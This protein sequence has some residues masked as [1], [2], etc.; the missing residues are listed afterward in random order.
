M[1]CLTLMLFMFIHFMALIIFFPA[2]L[3]TVPLHILYDGQQARLRQEK[4]FE[5]KR[6]EEELRRDR[7]NRRGRR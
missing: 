1:G 6:F 5:E 4:Q 2:L 7:R 3:I